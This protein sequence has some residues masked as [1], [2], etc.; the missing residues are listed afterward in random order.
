MPFGHVA[1]DPADLTEAGPAA[2]YDP[3][4]LDIAGELFDDALVTVN[5]DLVRNLLARSR[6]D[7]ALREQLGEDRI[8]SARAILADL[9][10]A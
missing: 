1:I 3:L 5:I 9:E 4:H 2:K 8:A 7:A 10:A 6:H